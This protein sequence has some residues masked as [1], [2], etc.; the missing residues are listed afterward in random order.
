MVNRKPKDMPSN[1]TFNGR[2]NPLKVL[3]LDHQM[4][5]DPYRIIDRI[6]SFNNMASY[7]QTMIA[8][9]RQYTY[10]I[11]SDRIHSEIKRICGDKI[12]EMGAGTGYWAK[13]LSQFDINII[14]F[15]KKETRVEYCDDVYYSDIFEGTEEVLG[16]YSKYALML[17]WPPYNEPFDYNCLKAYQGNYLI[18]VGE[19]YGG[20]TGDDDFFNLIE[21]EWEIVHCSYDCLNFFGIFSFETIYKRKSPYHPEVPLE[22]EIY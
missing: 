20:C 12:V 19:G 21:E 14:A 4:N 8:W 17:V 13:Y 5:I 16:E 22:S 2:W 11:P 18:Y 9:R 1:K 7:R 6:D 15:D 10:A 3:F